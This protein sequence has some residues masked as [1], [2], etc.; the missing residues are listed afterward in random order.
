M[1]TTTII[2]KINVSFFSYESDEYAGES[3]IEYVAVVSDE[4]GNEIKKLIND[5]KF[6]LLCM[7]EPYVNSVQHALYLG[8]QLEEL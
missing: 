6:G 8:S 1:I 7:L 2:D 3:V 5:S 4:K